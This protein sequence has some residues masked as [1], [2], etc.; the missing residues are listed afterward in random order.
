MCGIVGCFSVNN[1]FSDQDIRKASSAI[2]H[3]G[4]DG[5]GFYSDSFVQLAHRRLS[6][7][8][9]DKRASQ[10]MYS[11]CKRYMMVYNGE[12]YNYVELRKEIE[13]KFK[14]SP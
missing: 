5:D 13:S 4:P 7:I 2:N 14:N 1:T 9:L 12:V 3:R 8:D 10:P 6:I 11:S